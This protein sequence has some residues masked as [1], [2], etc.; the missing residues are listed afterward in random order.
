MA[1]KKT[2]K[3]K[4]VARKP[5]I[6]I[7]KKAAKVVEVKDPLKVTET[8][9]VEPVKVDKTSPELKRRLQCHLDYIKGLPINGMSTKRYV[10]EIISRLPEIIKEGGKAT[11]YNQAVAYLT[12]KIGG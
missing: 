2:T 8:K 10:S 7:R 5:V 1:T 11:V 12:E 3:K 6:K 4:A 9:I